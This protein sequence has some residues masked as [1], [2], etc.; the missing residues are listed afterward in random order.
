MLPPKAKKTA[1]KVTTKR[2]KRQV[3]C[4]FSGCNIIISSKSKVNEHLR[5]HTGEKPFCC[6]YKNCD[7]KF[8]Y[9]N[10]LTRHKRLH[11]GD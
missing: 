6:P 4:P 3:N 2:L 10:S 5:T 8:A 9:T 1:K 7:A 11:T